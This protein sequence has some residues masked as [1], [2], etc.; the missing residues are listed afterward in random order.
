MCTH[1]FGFPISVP[2]SHAPVRMWSPLAEVDHAAQRQIRNVSRLPWVHGVAVMPDV[3]A[4]AG[5]TVGSVI[6][7]S[8]AVSPAAVG[9]DI[10]CGMMAVKTT[11]TLMDLPSELAPLRSA[12]ESVVPVGFA[13][14]ATRAGILAVDGLLRREVKKLFSRFDALRVDV[15]A[16][17]HN[18]FRQ[19][20]TLGGG[21]HFIE[22][23]VDESGIVWIMLHSGSRNIGKE[24]AERH[25]ARA[26]NLEWNSDI[27]DRNLAVF[28]HRDED[29]REYP[30]WNDYLHDLYWAQ[31]Y[32]LMN[33][34][35]M[36]ASVKAKL[37]EFFPEC[38][39]LEEV[40][41]HHNYV[42]EE[43]YD[44]VDLIIT[45]KGAISAKKGELGIIP[46]S[47]GTGSFIV[48]GLGNPDSYCSASHGAG[49]R[50]SRGTA[51][52]T[53][54]LDDLIAQTSGV[55]CRKDY[56]VLDEIPGAYK[57]LNTVMEHQCDLVEVVAR[58]DT[59]LCVKG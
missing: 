26:R 51:R 6:A 44:D 29:G 52:E 8:Q 23:C 7:M 14:H 18:A 55:E 53:F 10:G 56:G 39:F 47:M 38:R 41:C 13:K 28:L 49:R 17:E 19:C 5:V 15:S 3:H 2:G 40:N 36:M 46:G 21:N 34:K 48:R 11:L 30:Q 1:P 37:L 43:R 57:D 4:G 20:G 9:S 59:L 16:A 32:A 50:V 12:W 27:P 33:R 42:S 54:S 31:D 45:R 25:I 22:L 24:L 35:V 58:L